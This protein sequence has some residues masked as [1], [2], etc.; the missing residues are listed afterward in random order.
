MPRA[1]LRTRLLD[2]GILD[3]GSIALIFERWSDADWAAHPALKHLDE[4]M[5]A[6]IDRV[7]GEAI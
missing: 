3:A 1:H 4:H 2:T 6:Y 7:R 5:K